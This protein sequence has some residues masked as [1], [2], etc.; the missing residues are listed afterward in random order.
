M[1]G[2]NFFNAL[3]V[4]S[5]VRKG[6]YNNGGVGAQQWLPASAPVPLQSEAAIS[7]RA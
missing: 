1:K 5:A 2:D 7:I 4:T 6:T 3:V